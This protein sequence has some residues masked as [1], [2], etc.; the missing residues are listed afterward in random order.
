MIGSYV[1]LDDKNVAYCGAR[2][3]SDQ[4]ETQVSVISII[5]CTKRKQ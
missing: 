2:I 1:I 4:R 3:G 5:L